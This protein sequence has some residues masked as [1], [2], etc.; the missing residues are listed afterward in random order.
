M[1][2]ERK[3]VLTYP[4]D[5]DLV[6]AK[7]LLNGF[8]TDFPQRMV[9]SLYYDF[10]DNDKTANLN[11]NSIREKS[12]IRWYD[13]SNKLRI[14]VKKKFGDLGTKNIKNISIHNSIDS[15]PSDFDK[16]DILKNDVEISKLLF[17]KTVVSFNKYLRGYY[18][19]PLLDLR[20]TIDTECFFHNLRGSGI[21]SRLNI[22]ISAIVEFKY[23][24]DNY[25][26]EKFVF[27]L[28]ADINKKFSRCSKFLFS[29]GD[30]LYV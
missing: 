24:F 14:E 9:H 22:P 20:V 10:N 1:R 4:S 30:S 7:V 29:T 8:V 27:V 16:I 17:P 15:Q 11:G 25:E 13:N 28:V 6:K 21:S 12:R 3:L 23:D 18:Y 2:Y 5:I 19:H 26:A